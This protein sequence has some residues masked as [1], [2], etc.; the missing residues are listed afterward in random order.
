MKVTPKFV[1]MTL[2]AAFGFFLV[3]LALLFG[4][5][6]PGLSGAGGLAVLG[7]FG[8][9]IGV[10]FLF[11]DFSYIQIAEDRRYSADGEWFG[12]LLL[13]TSLVFVYINVLRILGRR[14]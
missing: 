4:L 8:V 13:M 11:V 10:A 3:S 2:M 6:V 5:P 1:T 7:V 12:A 14:R 9:A